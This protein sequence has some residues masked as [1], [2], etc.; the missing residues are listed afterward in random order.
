MFIPFDEKIIEDKKKRTPLMVLII[1]LPILIVVGMYFLGTRNYPLYKKIGSEDN[2]IEW[3][4]FLA[5]VSSS[6]LTLLLSLRFKKVSK[7]MFVIFLILS[8][9]FLFVAGE[10]IS[11]GQRLFNIEGHELFRGEKSL[12][13]LGN[14][15]QS[16]TNL[17]NFAAIHSK[18]GYM[19]LGIGAYGIFSWLV[20]CI[21]T[22]TLKLKKE[23]KKYLKYFTVPPY[24]FLYFFATAINLKVVSR[25][26]VGPQEYE[27]AELILSLGI[28][29]TM[30]I[31]YISAKKDFPE[32]KSSK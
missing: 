26:G 7:F 16:E 9:G 5:Y 10:E 12:P 25:R 20:A 22:K 3:L 30:I 4:Q 24:L 15:V 14:N 31:Y 17:H 11:W 27:L 28:L 8:L 21:L 6:V 18:V 2:L 13:R 29:I 32:K 19:Y 23:I 1:I